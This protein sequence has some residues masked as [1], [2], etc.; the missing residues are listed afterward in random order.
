MPWR[1]PSTPAPR[2][3]SGSG[4]PPSW[5]WTGPSPSPTGPSVSPDEMGTMMTA[6]LDAL[7][8]PTEFLDYQAPAVREFVH[9]TLSAAGAVSD[10]DK[11]VALFYAV[12]D[13]ILYDVYDAD[14][15]RRGLTAG[16]V[17]ARGSGFCVHKAILY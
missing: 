17:L 6:E 5:A 1:A 4:W 15:S 10:I 8:L 14:L 13:G 9:G 2:R 7:R 11:A 16:G 3:S 12:R